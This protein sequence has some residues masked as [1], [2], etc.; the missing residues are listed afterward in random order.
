VTPTNTPT[1]STTPPP[2]QALL[3]MESGDDAFDTG[4]VNTDITSYMLAYNPLSWLGFQTSGL[5]TLSDPAQVDA[6]KHWIDWPG[7]ITGTTNNLNGTFKITIPQTNGGSDAFG[8]AIEAYKFVTTEVPSN[9][10]RGNIWY[11]VLAPLSMTNNQ[12]YDKVGINYNGNASSLTLTNTDPNTRAQNIVYSGSNFVNTTYRIYTNSS[13]WN[14]GAPGV[15]DTT[16]NY[17]RG[18]TLI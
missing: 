18:G 17:F 10:V 12:T 11:V 13:N 1:P 14:V 15:F 2:L 7:F 8:N 5:P 9:T 4:N 16:N 3:F 6:F